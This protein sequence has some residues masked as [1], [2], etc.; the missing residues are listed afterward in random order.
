[1]PPPQYV[2]LPIVTASVPLHSKSVCKNMARAS[3]APNNIHPL[4]LGTQMEKILDNFAELKLK[5]EVEQ[6]VVVFVFGSN[7]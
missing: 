2:T 1:M 6:E 4:I 5:S 3:G 7:V